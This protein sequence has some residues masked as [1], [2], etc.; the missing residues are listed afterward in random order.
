MRILPINPMAML[1]GGILYEGV[2]VLFPVAV[3]LVASIAMGATFSGGPLGLLAIFAMVAAWSIAYNGIF[4]VGALKTLDP[5]IGQAML[6]LF[7]PFL[8][9]S[10]VF[11]PRTLMP[12]FLKTISDHNPLSLVVEAAR[13]LMFGTA[14]SWSDFAVAAAVTVGVIVVFQTVA[15]A[16]YRRLVAAD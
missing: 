3:V 11:V 10:T 5:Q 7:V 14:F 1:I 9:T 15:L 2:R 4:Y 12:D 8:L 6:P 13:P 16:M